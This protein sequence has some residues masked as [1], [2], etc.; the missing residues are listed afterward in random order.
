MILANGLK[1][2]GN[3]YIFQH[4]GGPRVFQISR[5]ARSR[6]D[7]EKCRSFWL[8]NAD[9]RA[10]D[11]QDGLPLGLGQA[12]PGIVNRA[13]C[14]PCCVVAIPLILQGFI[15][16]VRVLPGVLRSGLEFGPNT[17]S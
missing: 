3:F 2:G 1:C 13:C 16:V 11:I 12:V 14:E 6:P 4:P 10:G 7:A 5:I 8:R 17:V 15:A 9:V